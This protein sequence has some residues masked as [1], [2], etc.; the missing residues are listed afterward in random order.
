MIVIFIPVLFY[1][2]IYVILATTI[3]GINSWSG[4]SWKNDSS[5]RPDELLWRQV[6]RHKI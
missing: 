4:T 5:E 6:R 3:F 1:N 2:R